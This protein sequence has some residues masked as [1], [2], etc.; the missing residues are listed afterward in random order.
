[1]NRANRAAVA[2][3]FN[4]PRDAERVGRA[5]PPVV[6]KSMRNNA[7]IAAELDELASRARCLPAPNH[8][9]PN[10]FHESRSELGRQIAAIAIFLRTGKRPADDEA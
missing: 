10:A 6:V 5:K 4:T 9:N 3:L 8:R 7:A 1:M 2:C